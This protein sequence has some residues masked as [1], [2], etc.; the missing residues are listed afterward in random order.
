MNNETVQRSIEDLRKRIE[1]YAIGECMLFAALH[2]AQVEHVMADIRFSGSD[3]THCSVV[4]EV[5]GKR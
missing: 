4:V 2:P 3:V 5:D 1:E